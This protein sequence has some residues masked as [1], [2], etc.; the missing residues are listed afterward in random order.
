MR[1]YKALHE[2]HYAALAAINNLYIEACAV[3]DALSIQPALSNLKFEVP[4]TG[5]KTSTVE[6]T[7]SALRALLQNAIVRREYEKSLMR[8][9]CAFPICR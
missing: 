4:S 3:V 8:P 6:R 7:P 9:G 2:H 1:N 5:D